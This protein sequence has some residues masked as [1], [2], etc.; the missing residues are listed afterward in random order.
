M[1][2]TQVTDVVKSYVSYGVPTD[3]WSWNKAV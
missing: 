1:N 2:I 3:N